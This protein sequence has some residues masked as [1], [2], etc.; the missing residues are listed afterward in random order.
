[1]IDIVTREIGD[2]PKGSGLSNAEID[3]NFL[4]LKAEIEVSVPQQILDGAFMAAI[5]YG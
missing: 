5:I 1:M 3:Q 4:N 2:N